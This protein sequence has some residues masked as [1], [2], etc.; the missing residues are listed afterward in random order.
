MLKQVRSNSTKIQ[1]R[2]KFDNRLGRYKHVQVMWNH[3]NK[4]QQNKRIQCKKNLITLIM[5]SL[6]KYWRYFHFIL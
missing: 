4:Y 6:G 1:I 3:K 5:D 2:L